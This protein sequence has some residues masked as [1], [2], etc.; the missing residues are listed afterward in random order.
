MLHFVS[1]SFLLMGLQA[2]LSSCHPWWSCSLQGHPKWAESLALLGSKVEKGLQ[3]W[4]AVGVALLSSKYNKHHTRPLCGHSSSPSL[5]LKTS[6][7]TPFQTF[8]PD[9]SVLSLQSQVLIAEIEE[10]FRCFVFFL[11]EKNGVYRL[12]S[13]IDLLLWSYLQL[14]SRSY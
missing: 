6:H 5:W 11:S 3:G 7:L 8:E 4:V 2:S 1:Q 13:L 14:M 10:T 12:S 9:S